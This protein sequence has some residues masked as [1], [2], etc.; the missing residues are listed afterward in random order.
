MMQW[1]MLTIDRRREREMEKGGEKVNVI[2]LQDKDI[3][4]LKTMKMFIHT[5]KYIFILP[6]IIII[7][8]A[9]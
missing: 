2:P 9:S 1:R 4:P 8:I 7:I 5:Y 3:G 6:I